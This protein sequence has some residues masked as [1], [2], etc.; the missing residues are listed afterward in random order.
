VQHPSFV[1][2]YARLVHQSAPH[3]FGL[4]RQWLREWEE[5]R[6]K[7]VSKNALLGWTTWLQARERLNKEQEELC[8]NRKF[9]RDESA[10]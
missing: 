8:A 2:D 9:P 10:M 5:E 3:E 7:R 4:F 1:A 6:G